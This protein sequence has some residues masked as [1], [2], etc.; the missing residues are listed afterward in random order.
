MLTGDLP[1]GVNL[2]VNGDFET[3][4]NDETFNVVN[5]FATARFYESDL[6]P[7]WTVADGDGDGSQR[8]N[9]LT[10]NN[11]RGTVVD[12]DSIPGQDDRLFQDVNVTVGQQYVFSF[13]YFGP[14]QIDGVNDPPS[15]E[16]E[17]LIKEPNSID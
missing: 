1:G 15:N 13:D 10:F 8:I 17:V 6:V 11:D 12:I 2:I 5:S 9:L 4:T 7:G 14:D 16:F 3:F